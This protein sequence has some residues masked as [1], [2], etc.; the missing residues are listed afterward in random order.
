MRKLEK[1]M[2]SFNTEQYNIPISMIQSKKIVYLWLSNVYDGLVILSEYGNIEW[3]IEK[4][5]TAHISGEELK[6]LNNNFCNS[7]N[8]NGFNTKLLNET[9]L[10]ASMLQLKN[11]KKNFLLSGITVWK[12]D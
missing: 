6:L 2:I 1:E 8:R 10:V 7:M 4:L 5:R 3:L 9:L 12:H 11:L